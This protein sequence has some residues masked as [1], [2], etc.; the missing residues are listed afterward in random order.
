MIILNISN[1]PP[2]NT[3]FG[4]VETIAPSLGKKPHNT[5]KPA[6]IPMVKRL[7]TFVIPISPTFWL[8]E[9]FG[10][11]PKMAANILPKPSA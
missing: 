2:P 8:N 3:G 5:K 11:T 10:I 6:P 4:I 7:T 9:V 1:T